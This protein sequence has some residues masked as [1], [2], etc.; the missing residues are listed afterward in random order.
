MFLE[1]QLYLSTYVCGHLVI[2]LMFKEDLT[3]TYNDLKE[4]HHYNV[5]YTPTFLGLFKILSQCTKLKIG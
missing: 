4:D 5:A 3:I 2:I 1:T